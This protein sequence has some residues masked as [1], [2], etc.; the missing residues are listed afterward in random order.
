[1]AVLKWRVSPFSSCGQNVVKF[2]CRKV[3]RERNEMLSPHAALVG[4]LAVGT[5]GG[6]YIHALHG[7]EE[8]KG[9]VT[10]PTTPSKGQHSQCPKT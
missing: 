2:S 4:R 3:V 6:D 1:M 7:E 8:I 5:R 10:D 9:E